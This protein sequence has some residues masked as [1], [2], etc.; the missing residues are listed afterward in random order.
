MRFMKYLTILLLLAVQYSVQSSSSGSSSS[1]DEEQALSN[2]VQ[3]ANTETSNGENSMN[4]LT[5]STTLKGEKK[6]GLFKNVLSKKKLLEG[7][8]KTKEGLKKATKKGKKLMG[9]MFN[10]L[11]SSLKKLSSK[12]EKSSSSSSSDSDSS[13]DQN[14]RQKR[15]LVIEKDKKN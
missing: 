15:F 2:E 3:L 11:K 7:T 14:D 4:A 10:G 1:S 8:K 9:K 5:D 12:K 13:E 6:K